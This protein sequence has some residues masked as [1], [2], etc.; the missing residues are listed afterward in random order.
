MI[1]S[2]IDKNVGLVKFLDIGLD[3]GK[4]LLILFLLA[5]QANCINDSYMG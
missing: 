3:C 4:F 1:R 2:L 5:F